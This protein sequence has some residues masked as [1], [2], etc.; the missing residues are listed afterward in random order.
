MRSICSKLAL[1]ALMLSLSGCALFQDRPGPPTYLGPREQIYYATFDEVW[2][3]VNLVLQP[4]PLRVSN[5]DQGV[6][7]TDTIRGFK[8]WT[9]PYAPNQASAGITYKM[10]IRVVKGTQQGSS[11]T[12]VVIDKDLEVQH[13]FFSSPTQM[14]SDG[15][16]EKSILYR[17]GREIQIERALKKAQARKNAG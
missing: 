15:M 8:T 7:E 17:V 9:P 1:A 3:A 4:Y 5:M 10:K 12:K 13:D 16:E 11:A 6:L 2:R 14:P